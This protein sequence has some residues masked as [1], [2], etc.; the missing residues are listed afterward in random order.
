M[1][2]ENKKKGKFDENSKIKKFYEPFQKKFER[3]KWNKKVRMS[4]KSIKGRNALS[5]HNHKRKVKFFENN[6]CLLKKKSQKKR[7]MKKFKNS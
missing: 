4:M 1:N 7:R 3:E 5:I 2:F 6:R